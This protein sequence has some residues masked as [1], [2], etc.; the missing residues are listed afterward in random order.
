VEALN[1]VY[2]ATVAAG[3]HRSLALTACGKV[4]WWRFRA[5]AESNSDCWPFPQLVDSAAFGGARVVSITASAGASFAVTDTGALF[6]WGW[7]FY[8][9]NSRHCSNYGTDQVRLSPWPVAGLNGVRVISVSAGYWHTLALAA[10]GEASTRSASAGLWASAGALV[11]ERTL[12]TSRKM[13]P[14]RRRVRRSFLVATVCSSLQRGS[15]A[16]FAPRPT[17]TGEIAEE[18]PDSSVASM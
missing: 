1:T 6:S 14:M 5:L 4:F 2:V 8:G 7:A 9:H 11:E 13:Q 17:R 12:R 16:W 10:D 18:R 15:P 3:G